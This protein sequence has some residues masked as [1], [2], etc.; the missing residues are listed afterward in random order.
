MGMGIEEMKKPGY[1]VLRGLQSRFS[2]G[3]TTVS[4][5]RFWSPGMGGWQ[6]WMQCVVMHLREVSAVAIGSEQPSEPGPEQ[7]AASLGLPIPGLGLPA[8]PRLESP[9]FSSG[10]LSNGSELGGATC[11]SSCQVLF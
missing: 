3:P 5:S 2:M 4:W 6:C 7:Q 10:L 11:R 8:N 1:S 9:G